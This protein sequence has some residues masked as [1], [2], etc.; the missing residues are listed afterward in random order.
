MFDDSRCAGSTSLPHT[1][2][3]N[4][5]PLTQILFAK[6]TARKLGKLFAWVLDSPGTYDGFG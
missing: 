3:S 2:P 4:S 5:S 1:L 6:D